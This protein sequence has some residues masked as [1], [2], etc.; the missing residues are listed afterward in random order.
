MS[1]DITFERA[2]RPV[3]YTSDVV[4]IG[5]SFGGVVVMI[6]IRRIVTEDIFI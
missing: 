6:G 3:L 4:V 1:I 2:T 5:G